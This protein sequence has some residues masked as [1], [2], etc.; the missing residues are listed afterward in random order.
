MRPASDTTSAASRSTR[1]SMTSNSRV[2]AIGDV[3]GGPQFTQ[4]PTI[5]PASSSAA[6]CFCCR[7][8]VNAEI[9][10]CVTYTDPE[11]AQVGLTEQQAREA[12]AHQRVALALP[13]ERPGPD[14]AATEGSSRSSP[15]PRARSW[16]PASSGE[17]AG[18]LVQ[19]WSLALSQGLNIKAMTQWISPYPTLSEINNRAAFGY[20]ATAPA[21][22]YCAQGDRTSLLSSGKGRQRE[23]SRAPRQQKRGA[24]VNFGGAF[25]RKSTLPRGPRRIVETLAR[26]RLARQAA[27][28]DGRLR[29]FGRSTD[30]PTVGVDVPR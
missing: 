17:H 22:P 2:Y 25:G 1:A 19:M 29:P 4:S 24:A 26:P 18:E 5:M 8:R 27:D 3:T 11:L 23:E 13:R 16:A 14:G 30:L 6:R 20:Y 12:T 7:P 15:T 21:N 28:V 9:L 10:P